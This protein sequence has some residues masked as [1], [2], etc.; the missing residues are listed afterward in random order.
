M[1]VASGHAVDAGDTGGEDAWAVLT[2]TVKDP[3][4]KTR[5]VLTE[6][7]WKEFVRQ[8]GDRS[9]PPQALVELMRSKPPWA[10]CRGGA[11]AGQRER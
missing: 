4:D 3:L 8:L 5:F 2:M 1:A 10:R 7:E 11:A 6:A 9:P